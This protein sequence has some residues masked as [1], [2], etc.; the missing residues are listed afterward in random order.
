MFQSH[1]QET[2]RHLRACPVWA[3][4]RFA[5]VCCR[6]GQGADLLPSGWG[7]P[8]HGHDAV[9]GWI[10]DGNKGKHACLALSVL[11]THVGSFPQRAGAAGDGGGG[12]CRSGQPS[13]RGGAGA[14]ALESCAG[15][16]PKQTWTTADSCCLECVVRR[17]GHVPAIDPNGSGRSGDDAS[18]VPIGS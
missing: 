13:S 1:H 9:G 10:A 18:V 17:Q 16:Q 7:A 8:L 6:R 5:A 11:P 4:A 2:S 15:T 3:P 14:L 12:L